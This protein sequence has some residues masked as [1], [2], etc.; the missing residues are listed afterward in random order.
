VRLPSDLGLLPPALGRFMS[1]I[2]ALDGIA[3]EDWVQPGPTMC[4]FTL[5][6]LKT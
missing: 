6:S 4:V 5:T 1:G 3:P 2:G